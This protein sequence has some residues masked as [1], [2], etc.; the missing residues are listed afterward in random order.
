M[1]TLKKH[2][3]YQSRINGYL[4]KQ[5]NLLPKN[6]AKLLEAMRYRLLIGGKRMRPYL[7]YITG[8]ALGANLNDI[9]AITACVVR[10]SQQDHLG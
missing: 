4:E 9:D 3:I 7:A 1:I 8:E 5:L 2:A 6:D 10:F